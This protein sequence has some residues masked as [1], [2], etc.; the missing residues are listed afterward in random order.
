ATSQYARRES[1]ELIGTVVATHDVTLLAVAIRSR[2]EFLST[3]SHELRTP[4]TSILGYLEVMEDHP[5]FADTGMA[6]EVDAIQR[7]SHRLHALISALIT[8]ARG[9][10]SVDRRPYDVSRLVGNSVNAAQEKAQKASVTVTADELPVTIAE[11]D[12]DHINSVIDALITNGIT[13]TDPGG[14]VN[15]SVSNDDENL[16]ISVADTGIGMNAD[17]LGHIFDRFFRASSARKNEVPGSGLGL[18]AAKTVV[19]AHH[20]TITATSIEGTGTTVVVRLPLHSIDVGEQGSAVATA[21][22]L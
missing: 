1:G 14:A 11:I 8:T 2:D 15:V 5:D 21:A 12:A 7:N 22:T 9:Q 16:V 4:L 18:T 10:L 20:G 17:D 13:F 19:E 3:I 6:K